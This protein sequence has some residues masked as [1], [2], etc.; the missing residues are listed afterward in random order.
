MN[1]GS[2]VHEVATDCG[3]CYND[4]LVLVQQE[5][6]CIKQKLHKN[7]SFYVS[8]IGCLLLTEEGNYDFEPL[9]CGVLAPDLYGLDS[10]YIEP[11]KP[12]ETSADN[13]DQADQ[14]A[15]ANTV[16]DSFIFRIPK[17]VIRYAVAVAVAAVLYFVCIAPVQTAMKDSPAE[18]SMLLDQWRMVTAKLQKTPTPV[19]ADA[20]KATAESQ[21][22]S[23]SVPKN[24]TK[25]AAAAESYANAKDSATTKTASR[26]K[27]ARYVPVAKAPY[28]IVIASAVPEAGARRMVKDLRRGGVKGARVHYDCSMFRVVYGAYTSEGEAHNALRQLRSTHNEVFA[29]SWIC[30]VQ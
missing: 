13:A 12:E 23:A 6:L 29:H 20:I 26:V 16:K 15:E 5:V 2:L 27:S 18:A 3:I 19:S 10:I 24:G 4:A 8:G 9:L 1:D 14:A 17:N 28:T 11:V 25:T 21:K 7:G 30:C 22:A